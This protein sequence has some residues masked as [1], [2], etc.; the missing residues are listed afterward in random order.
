MACQKFNTPFKEK[1]LLILLLYFSKSSYKESHSKQGRNKRANLKASIGL[2]CRSEPTFISHDQTHLQKITLIP[3]IYSLP[4][5]HWKDGRSNG[6]QLSERA[7]H[8][9]KCPGL[10]S[11]DLHSG[12][13]SGL[14]NCELAVLCFLICKRVILLFTQ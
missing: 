9:G 2:H 4:C 13:G 12:L 11:S 10:E 8:R 3:R 1:Y 5:R 6:P 14:K 7:S